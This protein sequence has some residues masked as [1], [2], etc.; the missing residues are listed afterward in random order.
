LN[1]QT[2]ERFVKVDEQFLLRY[3]SIQRG[4]SVVKDV[5]VEVEVET[6]KR[7][8]WQRNTNIRQRAR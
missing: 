5:E 1:T 7:G 6:L 2:L 3:W 8:G 4:R